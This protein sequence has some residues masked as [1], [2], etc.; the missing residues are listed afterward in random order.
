MHVAITIH[1]LDGVGKIYDSAET[2]V[3]GDQPRCISYCFKSG[4]WRPEI[5]Y[6]EHEY[7]YTQRGK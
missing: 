1:Y 3:E 2:L 4:S 5:F 7:F 6:S